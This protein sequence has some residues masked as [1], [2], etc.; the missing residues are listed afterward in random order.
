MRASV[1]RAWYS[2]GLAQ[3]LVKAGIS[4]INANLVCNMDSAHPGRGR[5][6]CTHLTDSME[7][8]SGDSVYIGEVVRLPDTHG[9]Q[10]FGPVEFEVWDSGET[11]PQFE[12]IEKASELQLA[13]W[14]RALPVPGERNG[15]PVVREFEAAVMARIS[16][17]YVS[18]RGECGMIVV[19]Q[20]RATL[21]EEE[22][23]EA[24]V[25]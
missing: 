24:A 15:D 8:P 10:I 11:Y 1:K 16:E 22:T 18:L 5:V 3:A 19:P 9:Y 4:L 6:Y 23:I 7:A 20:F 25:A 12:D 2:P 21:S 13:Y 17:R 14:L